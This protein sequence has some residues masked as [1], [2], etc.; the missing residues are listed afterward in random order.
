MVSIARTVMPYLSNVVPT[1]SMMRAA[2]SPS[3]PDITSSCFIELITVLRLLYTTVSMRYSAFAMLPDSV[4]INFSG[5]VM[6][7][8]TKLSATM[9][10]LSLVITSLTARSYSISVLGR[11]L[12]VWMNGSFMLSPGA[13]T[14]RTT[15]P[16]WRTM[17]YSF[18]CVVKKQPPIMH[19]ISS[20]ATIGRA[21]FSVF[22]ITYPLPY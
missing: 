21:I 7:Q 14:M 1:F 2:S 16:N 6:R 5:S 18:C 15:L 9:D 17:L 20:T 8:S 13:S 3:R 12:T 22:F 4:W 10:F 11:V 19:T